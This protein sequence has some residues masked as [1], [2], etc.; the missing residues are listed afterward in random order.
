MDQAE[1]APDIKIL[2]LNAA[3]LGTDPPIWRRFQVSDRMTLG[4]L[5]HVLQIVMGWNNFHLHEFYIDDSTFGACLSPDYDSEPLENENAYEL[6]KV[7]PATGGVFHYIYDFGD[8]WEHQIT[9]ETIGEPEAGI[10]YPRCLDGARSRP[11]EDCG[12]IPGFHNILAI[13]DDPSHEEHEEVLD[14][15]GEGFDPEEFDVACVNKDLENFDE[16]RLLEMGCDERALLDDMP[17]EGDLSID[18]GG[19]VR[20]L[21]TIGEPPDD[22]DY[23]VFELNE[24]HVPELIRMAGDMALHKAPTESDWIWAPVHAWRALGQLGAEE[25]IEPLT[26]LLRIVDELDDDWALRDLPNVLSSFGAKAIPAA[27]AFLHDTSRGLWGRV[28]SSDTLT[29]IGQRYPDARPE[30]VAALTEELERFAQNDPDLNAFVI[31]ALVDLEAVESA[32][33]IEQVFAARAVE[34]YVRGDWEDIQMDLGLLDERITPPPAPGWLFSGPSDTGSRKRQHGK[35]SSQSGTQD[36][37]KNKNKRKRERK[38][39]KKNRRK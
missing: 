34:L 36:K 33:V 8:S 24:R 6:R 26:D 18:Y 9:V 2:T 38:A 28:T 13:L 27:K 31:S 7:L 17:S 29:K 21:L 10:P 14:W 37:K 23:R 1:K 12:G 32:N 15:L 30:C 39:R 11:P 16:W 5:H 35:L 3:L 22:L 4:D 25:A 20:E 19:P